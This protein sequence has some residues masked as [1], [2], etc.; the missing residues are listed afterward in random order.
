MEYEAGL[1]IN[2]TKNTVISAVNPHKQIYPASMTKIMT[3]VVV[4]EA[5]NSGSISLQEIGR[6]HV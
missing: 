1:L 5:V 2:Q 3:A 4:M 6:A